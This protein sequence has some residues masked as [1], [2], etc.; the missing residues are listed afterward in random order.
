MKRCKRIIAF[1]LLGSILISF[2][3]CGKETVFPDNVISIFEN[4]LLSVSSNVLTEEQELQGKKTEG[5]YAYTGT[6]EAEYADFSGKEYLFGAT[7]LERDFGNDLTLTYTLNVTSGSGRL[8]WREKD[9]IH[10]IAD[11][12][13]E[14]IY[15]ISL[16]SGDQYIVMEGEHFTGSL[17]ITVE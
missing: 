3:G 4:F 13:Q 8:Y 16:S 12:A 9:K 2:A 6:Y 1:A 10:L 11:A 17:A 5:A 7:S 15:T 14:G